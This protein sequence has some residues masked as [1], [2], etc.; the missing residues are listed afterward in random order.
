[1]YTYDKQKYMQGNIGKDTEI[2]YRHEP[3]E[4]FRRNFQRSSKR[5]CLIESLVIARLMRSLSDNFRT[6][7]K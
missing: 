2:L 7:I 5:L 4:L 3:S 1:M 6:Y